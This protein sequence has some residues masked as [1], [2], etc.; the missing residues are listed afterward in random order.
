M[1]LG[2]V[3]G[4]TKSATFQATLTVHELIQVPLLHA[5]FKVKWKFK[6][7]TTIALE[8][9]D[10]TSSLSLSHS[11]STGGFGKRFLHPRSALHN[12][13]SNSNNGTLPSASSAG[14]LSSGGGMSRSR[15]KSPAG[16]GWDSAGSDDVTSGG[17][18]IV[19]PAQSPPQSPEGAGGR[20]PNPNRTPAVN[21]ANPTFAF[22]SPFSANAETLY[23][24]GR[25]TTYD[26]VGSED[27]GLSSSVAKRRGAADAASAPTLA[28]AGGKDATVGANRPLPKGSTNY[29]PLRDPHTA[30]FNRTICCPVQIPLRH[31]APNTLTVKGSKAKYQLQPSPVRLSVK[32]EVVTD[33]NKR[34]EVK[35]GEVVL[36]LSQF[37][38]RAAGTKDSEERPRRYLLQDCKSNAVLKVSVKM[39]LIDADVNFIAPQLGTGQISTTAPA[40]K[41]LHSSQ[42]SPTNRSTASLGKHNS[43]S[44][45]NLPALAAA[46]RLST[47]TFSTSRSSNLS[48][49]HGVT[50]TS[51]LSS[52]GT[53][54]SSR[55]SPASSDQ[56]KF[57][58]LTARTGSAATSVNGKK[59]RN[60]KGWHPPSSALALATA[61]TTLLSSASSACVPS[62]AHTTTPSYTS[63][64]AHGGER[65]ASD[66]IN[67]IF[68]RPK[69]AP[70]WVGFSTAVLP[71]TPGFGDDAEEFPYT[72]TPNGLLGNP[73]EYDSSQGKGRKNRRSAPSRAMSDSGHLSAGEKDKAGKAWSIR[74][75]IERQ[76]EKKRQKEQLKAGG[77]GAER[78]GERRPQLRVQGPARAA[79]DDERDEQRTP[80]PPNAAGFRPSVQVQPPTPQTSFS[81]SARGQQPPSRPPPPPPIN[82]GPT[83]RPASLASFGTGPNGRALSV[84]WGDAPTPLSSASNSPP[85]TAP[86]TLPP[87]SHTST[88][89]A[90]R[91]S[92]RHSKS[93]DSTLSTS[94]RSVLSTRSQRS[95]KDFNPGLGLSASSTPSATPSPSSTPSSSAAPSPEK[96][97]DFASSPSSYSS[98]PPSQISFNSVV[99]PPSPEKKSFAGQ[100][101]Q[102]DV[103]GKG[104]RVAPGEKAPGGMEWG[105][106]WS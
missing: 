43:A 73:F 103:Q 72:P 42:N 36:D 4:L 65:A 49:P 45:T 78:D 95:Q 93:N 67:A 16:R 82:G 63:T 59:G 3:L 77:A 52:T 94:A 58:G 60:K 44:S 69:R 55:N 24:H 100:Q 57:P 33:E 89:G 92:L 97:K 101:Q 86:S 27:T 50:R 20:T 17:E 85:S 18:G 51:S 56:N 28:A 29:V 83:T 74:S 38:G 2:D 35:L 19:S 81:T 31:L 41:G 75:G 71:P 34:E 11:H 13:T 6:G 10:S 66:V 102:Q 84:R 99:T 70:S 76:K 47:S 61:S 62:S 5:R 54:G 21:N 87:S 68:N 9:D 30:T 106:S 105:K 80:R 26:T 25:S 46:S 91:R 14:G 104:K 7:A 96:A 12:V 8:G 40:V 53:G 48:S 88:S 79:T 22:T 98:R 39:E 64:G 23:T 32:Q 90:D 15:S 37:V 1:G